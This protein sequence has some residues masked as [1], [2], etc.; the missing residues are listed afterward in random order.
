MNV[1]DL[2]VGMY[3]CSETCPVHHGMQCYLKCMVSELDNER[4][5]FWVTTS[6]DKRIVRLYE[7]AQDWFEVE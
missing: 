6:D 4:K 2:Q 7:E 3:V 1:N 5:T